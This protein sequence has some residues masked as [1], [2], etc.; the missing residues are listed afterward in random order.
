MVSPCPVIHPLSFSDLSAQKPNPSS[1]MAPH[2]WW[3]QQAR[4]LEAELKKNP[5]CST[6]SFSQSQTSPSSSFLSAGAEVLGQNRGGLLNINFPKSTF[7]PPNPDP[8]LN[9]QRNHPSW[10]RV[11][12]KRPSTEMKFHQFFLKQNGTSTTSNNHRRRTT[13][14][15]NRLFVIGIIFHFFVVCP[16]ARKFICYAGVPLSLLHLTIDQ[17]LFQPIDLCFVSM[18]F[19]KIQISTQST[20]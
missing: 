7:N 8:N 9:P 13:L 3:L 4:G 15:K 16:S 11:P 19:S 1:P 6:L 14:P 5:L 2:D 10:V 12:V 17:L 18:F 20:A